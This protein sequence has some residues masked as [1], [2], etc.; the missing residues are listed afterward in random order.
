MDRYKQRLID[1]LNRE[2]LEAAEQQPQANLFDEGG[3]AKMNNYINNVLMPWI[4]NGGDIYVFR[5]M[6]GQ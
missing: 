5:T 4:V 6:V 2:R 3:N 1:R